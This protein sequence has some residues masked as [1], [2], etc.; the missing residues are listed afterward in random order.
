MSS[1]NVS[2]YFCAYETFKLIYTHNTHY[3]IKYIYL[4]YR[5][6]RDKICVLLLL[7]PSLKW[8]YFRGKKGHSFC[9]FENI[10]WLAAI[11]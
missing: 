11:Y 8:H 4:L 2:I 10:G 1:I 7:R 9:T 5:N 6:V 3:I